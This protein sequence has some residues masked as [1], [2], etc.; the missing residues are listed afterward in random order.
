MT[1]RMIKALLALHSCL[2][3]PGMWGEGEGEK[4]EEG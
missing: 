1:N 3:Q 2:A 4:E